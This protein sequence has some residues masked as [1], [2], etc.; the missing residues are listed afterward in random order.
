VIP[1]G[2]SSCIPEERKDSA[3]MTS[4]DMVE[5]VAACVSSKDLDDEACYDLVRTVRRLGGN[6]H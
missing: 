2:K 6:A 4:L 1:V 3:L 5:E